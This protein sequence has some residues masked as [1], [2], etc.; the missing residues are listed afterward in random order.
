MK[1]DKNIQTQKFK[2]KI[3]ENLQKYFPPFLNI[4]KNR[5]KRK[6]KGKERK[7]SYLLFTFY[8]I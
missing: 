2:E 6:M 4:Y 8:L 5:N 1:N 3:F 7:F